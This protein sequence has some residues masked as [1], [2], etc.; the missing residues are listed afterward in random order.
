MPLIVGFHGGKSSGSV[1]STT[2]YLAR[3][4]SKR[5]EAIIIAPANTKDSSNWNTGMKQA[6]EIIYAIIKIY[7]NSY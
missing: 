5:P 4:N 2:H 6:R 3:E 7:K 1:N